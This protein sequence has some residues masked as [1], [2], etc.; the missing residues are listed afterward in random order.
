VLLRDDRG[1]KEIVVM[2]VHDSQQLEWW[3]RQRI[4]R[5][6]VI[7]ARGKARGRGR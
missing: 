4:G 2:R 1:D 5:T 3:A 7:D 6:V